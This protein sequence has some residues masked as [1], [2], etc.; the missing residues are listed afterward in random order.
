MTTS[1][2][3]D[4]NPYD[5]ILNDYL[6]DSLLDMLTAGMLP[7]ETRRDLW[8]SVFEIIRDDLP[9]VFTQGERQM[10]LDAAKKKIKYLKLGESE[11]EDLRELFMGA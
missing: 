8:R 5:E 4:L 1:E 9:T 3:R 7:L 6:V 10:Y 2:A 11:N